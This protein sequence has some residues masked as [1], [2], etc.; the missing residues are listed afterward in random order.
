[1][2]ELREQIEEMQRD[3][4]RLGDDIALMHAGVRLVHRMLERAS[5]DQ[6]HIEFLSH[7]YAFVSFLPSI[8]GVLVAVGVLTL[9][10][11][12]P[13]PF[14]MV[15]FAGILSLL[16]PLLMLML[17]RQYRTEAADRFNLLQQRRQRRSANQYQE[18]DR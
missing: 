3:I 11:L 7:Q 16:S 14:A 13:V 18:Q 9:A 10:D 5:E 17:S 1:M 12:D 6:A 2:S 4:A 15:V 8:G